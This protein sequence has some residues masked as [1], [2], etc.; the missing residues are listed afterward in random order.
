[1]KTTSPKDHALTA[2]G[3]LLWALT[4]LVLASVVPVVGI[5]MDWAS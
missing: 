3:C 4:L 1:M 5:L 2:L